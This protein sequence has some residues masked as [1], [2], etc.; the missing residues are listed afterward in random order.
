MMLQDL[1]GTII[2]DRFVVERE[3]GHGG[4]GAVY[5]ARDRKLHDKRVVVKVLLDRSFH[6]EWV[7]LKFQ[8]ERE[9]LSRVDHPGIVGIL[10]AGELPDG[11]P[12]IV[13][14]YI[15]G[16]TLREAL[17]ERPEGMDLTRAA[18]ILK[19]C[20]LALTAVHEKKIFHRDLKPENIMLQRL[21]RGEEQVKIVDFGVAKVRESALAPS[22]VT[23]GPTAGTIVYMSPEQL[24]GEKV[25]AASDIYALGIIAYE[26]VTG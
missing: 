16:V 4:V 9:A 26:M 6:D 15:D 1:I 13:M 8:Q 19:Q 24:R 10:D 12:Y 7:T 3:L 2:G 25:T 14:Q 18:S 5:L 20:G 21:G 22:T 17:E 23:G 11:K